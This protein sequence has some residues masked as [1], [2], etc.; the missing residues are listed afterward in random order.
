MTFSDVENPPLYELLSDSGYLDPVRARRI[1]LMLI[2]EHFSDPRNYLDSSISSLFYSKEADSTL[3]VEL[4]FTYDS[5]DI[6]KKPVIYV[7]TGPYRFKKQVIDNYENIS[8]DNSVIQTTTECVTTLAIRH[9]T[10]S[11]DLSLSLASQTTQF[12]GSIREM[13]WQNIPGILVYEVSELTP[14]ALIDPEKIKIFQ[15]NVNI[16]LGFNM[17]WITRIESLRIKEILFKPEARSGF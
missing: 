12:L 4:D 15:S 6:G 10:T 9:I 2:R 16:S 17:T 8:H 5:E 11:S 1:F 7:G 14:P 3:D 13:L